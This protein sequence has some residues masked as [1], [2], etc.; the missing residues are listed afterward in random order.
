LKE[1]SNDRTIAG[2]ALSGVLVFLMALS[3]R[4][5]ED[6]GAR[7]VGQVVGGVVLPFLL[8][9][10]IWSLIWRFAGRKDGRPW[11]SAWIGVIAVIVALMSAIGQNA[12][13]TQSS[14]ALLVG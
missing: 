9:A 1:S 8:G 7:Q 14:L 6:E 2:L 10:G 11:L 5:P 4:E 13:T 12:D 3:I